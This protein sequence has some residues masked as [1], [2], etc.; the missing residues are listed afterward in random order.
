M[1]VKFPEIECGVVVCST[2]HKF[3]FIKSTTGAL[4]KKTFEKVLFNLIGSVETFSVVKWI[5]LLT[6]IYLY[7]ASNQ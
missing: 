5:F 1:N 4:K 2:V 7:F 3:R 6:F